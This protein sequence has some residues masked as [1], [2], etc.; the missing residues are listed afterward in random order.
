MNGTTNGRVQVEDSL[1]TVAWTEAGFLPAQD[2]LYNITNIKQVKQV[3][4]IPDVCI[5]N[6]EERQLKRS[7]ADDLVDQ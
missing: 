2:Y 5:D 6:I 3:L 4:Y 7:C 1:D